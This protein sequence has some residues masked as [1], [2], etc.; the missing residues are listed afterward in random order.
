MELREYLDIIFAKRKRD[1]QEN[2]KISSWIKLPKSLKKMDGHR[3]PANNF[4]CKK[5]NMVFIERAGE[6]AICEN[7]HKTYQMN[8]AVIY[9]K[10][11]NQVTL[12]DNLN[13]QKVR[14]IQL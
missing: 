10:I 5:C 8:T 7:G 6:Y 12:S 1:K 9:I 13:F 4:W 11:P 2:R 14:R 3:E